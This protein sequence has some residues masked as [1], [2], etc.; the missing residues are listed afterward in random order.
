MKATQTAY[1]QDRFHR[2]QSSDPAGFLEMLRDRGFSAFSR[3]GLPGPK[4]EEWK[5]TDVTALFDAPYRLAFEEET[6]A[7]PAAWKSG[8]LPG[9]RQANELVFLNGRYEPGLSV[10]R[11]P[12][13]E[14]EILP[15]ETAASGAYSE[16]VKSH[17][18]KSSEVVKDG[19]QA[20]NTSFIYGGLFIHVP[21]R[22]TV[23]HPVYIYHVADTTHHPVLAQPRSLVIVE[24][25]AFLDL[26]ET[27]MTTG[28]HDSFTNGVLEIV[29]NLDAR[30]EYCRIQNDV[31]HASSV[32]TTH[33]RQTGKSFVNTVVVS[34][35]GG[36]IRNN[37]NLILEAAGNEAHMYGLYLLKGQTH[38]DNHTMVDNRQPNCFSNEYYKGILDEKSTG[39]F[40]GKIFVRPDAQKTNAYQSNK[41]IL[42]SDDASVNTKPQLEIYADDVKC[43]HGCTVGQLDEEALF[44]LRSR[45]IPAAHARSMLLHAFADDIVQHI[46]LEPLR[47]HV[48]HLIT[49]R[50]FIP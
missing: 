26:V 15:L 36:V 17:L 23:S 6:G 47:E 28:S 43:S 33:I 42:L 5:Y 25:A 18:D 13:E 24:R 3:S 37:V 48:Q 39:V 14:L 12:K 21:E 19:L 50:L 2:L 41:N 1:L 49:D 44:Y 10:I 40:N 31:P 4:N 38:V 32:S 9:A 22:A 35:N 20:L 46:R 7:L 16:L 30:V 8:R 34:L 29:A 45:G 11:S 27:F